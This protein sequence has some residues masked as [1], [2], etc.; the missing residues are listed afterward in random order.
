[1]LF[2]LSPAKSLE[3]ERPLPAGLGHTLPPFIPQSTQ[4][5]EVLRQLPPQEVA[6][7]MSISDKLAQLNDFRRENTHNYC[8]NRT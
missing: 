6:A 3:Y 4:L 7:L 2:L 5:I 8:N 1:M